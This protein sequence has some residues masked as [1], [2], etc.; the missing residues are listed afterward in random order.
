MLRIPFKWLEFAFECFESLSK[1]YNLQWNDSNLFRMVRSW[2]LK[3]RIAFE[4]FEFGFESF[5][6]FSNRSNLL[7]NAVNLF[8][9]VR[10][11]IRML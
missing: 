3:I 7:S 6:C 9:M 2:I 4:W 5:E 10:I 1:G 11:Y 8:R